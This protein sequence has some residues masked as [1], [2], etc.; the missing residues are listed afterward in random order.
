MAD[1]DSEVKYD[2]SIWK[3]KTSK[4]NGGKKYYYNRFTKESRWDPPSSDVSK[5][6]NPGI[7]FISYCRFVSLQIY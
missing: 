6:F 4:S 5:F 7:L 2:K 3:V 1:K